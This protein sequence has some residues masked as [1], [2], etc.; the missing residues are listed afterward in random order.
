MIKYNTLLVVHLF[1]TLSFLSANQVRDT[2]ES[3]MEWK[4]GVSK[5]I[6]TPEEPM[7]MG[8]YSARDRESEGKRHEL[9]TKAL[10]FEDAEG[11]RAVL[12]TAD[13]RNFPKDIS[14][15]IRDRIEEEY[16]LSR[17]QVL[18]N[19]SHTHSGP[20]VN[21]YINIT[22]NIARLNREQ[23]ERV[24]QYT[25]GLEDTIVNLVGEALES[26][27]PATLYAE[28]GVARFAVNRRNN[29]ASTINEVT[30]L[31]GPSDHAVPVIKVLDGSGEVM[32]ITFG[33]ACHPSVLFD[34]KFSGDY[35]GYAQLELEKV[36][37]EATA[38][39]FQGAGGDQGTI[40]R[41]SVGYARQY[42]QELAVAV[43]RVL[44]EDMRQLPSQLSTAYSEVDIALSTPPSYEELIRLEEELSGNRKRWATRLREQLDRGES[45]QTSHPYPVQ[46]WQIGDQTM[47]NLGG[48]LV[49][50]YAINIKRIFGQDTFVLGY[51]N[52]VMS[53]IPTVEVLR[54]GG[55][56]GSASQL[57][58]GMPSDWSASIETT[59]LAE[60]LKVAEE[61][62]VLPYED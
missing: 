6:I 44:S 60:V 3:S 26:M 18:L 36:Y 24:E 27:E 16:N 21:S 43:R 39:F 33:Y 42:G 12:I 9:W 49:V 19:G 23:K 20:L 61:A 62:G 53:Y 55:Y 59:I 41:R 2:N 4:A 7:W 8:G 52:D 14:D 1:F 30:Q 25:A 51:S 31:A 48:E 45:I 17:D 57:V 32:A 54:E 50:E 22:H 40:P 38:L 15:R 58:R 5:V 47:V 35:V 10:A 37:P 28:N 13:I 29:H 11:K 34:Y 56:E 46:V